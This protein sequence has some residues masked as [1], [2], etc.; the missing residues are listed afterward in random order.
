M[1]WKIYN[2]ANVVIIIILKKIKREHYNNNNLSIFTYGTPKN[3]KLEANSKAM[4]IYKHNS[5]KSFGFR[6]WKNM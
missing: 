3:L 2:Q 4:S 5:E 1:E 6:F